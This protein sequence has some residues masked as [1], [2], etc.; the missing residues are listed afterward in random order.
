[1]RDWQAF[2]YLERGQM[3]KVDVLDKGYVRLRDHMGDDLTVVDAAR[4]SFDKKSSWVFRPSASA[5]AAPVDVNH[6]GIEKYLMNRDVKLLDFL[7][8]YNHWS[9]FSHPHVMLEV[10]APVMVINQ[11]YKHRIGA[12]FTEIMM[13][14]GT[15]DDAWN[16]MSGRYVSEDLEFHIP[17]LWRSAPNNKKQG[18]GD[19]LSD[20][21]CDILTSGMREL[22]R[23]GLTAYERAMEEFGAAP[24]QA[25]LFLPYAAMYS[26]LIWS[27]SL[28][29]I[30]RTLQL[31]EDAHAQWEI[32]EYA[33]AIRQ[34]VEPL[35]PA[36]FKAFETAAA[37]G[38]LETAK[39]EFLVAYLTEWTGEDVLED[40]Q[41]AWEEKVA[42]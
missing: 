29:T 34:L 25:R 31:R 33:D 18:S 35:Y 7:A 22:V 42:V 40:A 24:E 17:R 20:P 37:H 3:S 10:K 21:C 19:L 5:L 9:P 32:R 30:M 23:H 27:P 28:Y 13:G 14:E 11:L 4:V 39:L 8:E 15:F 36:S 6:G 1:M 12:R 41:A 16:E 26:K 38:D 2:T